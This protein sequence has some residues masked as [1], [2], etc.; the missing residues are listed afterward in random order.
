MIQQ[1]LKIM[2]IQRNDLWC[3]SFLNE[4]HTKYNYKYSYPIEREP[5]V[6]QVQVEVYCEICQ[7]PTNHNTRHFPHKLKNEKPKWCVICE[8]ESHLTQECQLNGQNKSN[9]HIVY[10]MQV[11]DQT[12]E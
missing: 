1:S 11:V 3:T 4:G 10:H 9:Y 8:E 2:S 7:S 5:K 12:M 6:R